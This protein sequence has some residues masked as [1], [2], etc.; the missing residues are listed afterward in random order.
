M[1]DREAFGQSAS[2]VRLMRTGVEREAQQQAEIG[3]KTARALIGFSWRIPAATI[4]V[5]LG[6]LKRAVA[7]HRT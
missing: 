4:G 5:R 6:N 1:G 3:K 2:D 7:G